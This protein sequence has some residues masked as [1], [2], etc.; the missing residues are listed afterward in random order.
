MDGRYVDIVAHRRSLS[1]ARHDE[2]RIEARFDRR[3]AQ[4]YLPLARRGKP[5]HRM[6]DDG[7]IIASLQD[8]AATKGRSPKCTDW[9]RAGWDRPSAITV[10]LR[11]GGWRKALRRAGLTPDGREYDRAAPRCYRQWSSAAIVRALR[12]AT[13][14]AGRSP[15]STEWF[16][17]GPDHPCSTTVRERFGSWAAALDAAGV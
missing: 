2:R 8:W 11:F 17:A 3:E 5:L 7:E 13:R 6:W 12:D 4:R 15:R 16:R 14:A 1:T 10:R 9:V